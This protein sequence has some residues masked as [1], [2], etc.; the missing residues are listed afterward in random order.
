MSTTKMHS[1]ASPDSVPQCPSSITVQRPHYNSR[2]VRGEHHCGA[3]VG[4]QLLECSPDFH[5][6]WVP[7][8]CQCRVKSG[9]SHL[10]SQ[11]RTQENQ[12]VKVILS[13]MASLG[14][15]HPDSDCSVGTGQIQDSGGS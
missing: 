2:T 8:R 9:V 14:Y 4:L 3:E 10:E 13:C 7:P 5:K 15:R 1:P 11:H 6:P 12:T